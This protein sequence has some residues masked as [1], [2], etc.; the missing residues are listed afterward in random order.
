MNVF[1]NDAIARSGRQELGKQLAE[2]FEVVVDGRRLFRV[3]TALPFEGLEFV[4]EGRLSVSGDEVPE[5]HPSLKET[6]HSD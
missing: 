2:T 4:V 1:P 6:T 3:R 5:V